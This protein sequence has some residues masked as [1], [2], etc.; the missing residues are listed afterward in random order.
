[1]DILAFHASGRR[2]HVTTQ[3]RFRGI[4][5]ILGPEGACGAMY[6]G[7]RTRARM[8]GGGVLGLSLICGGCARPGIFARCAQQY[9]LPPVRFGLADPCVRIR[10]SRLEG[11]LD[12][13]LCCGGCAG[14]IR[15]DVQ[16]LGSA[17]CGR[18]LLYERSRGQAEQIEQRTWICWWR[19]SYRAHKQANR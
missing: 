4:L 8:D 5:L 16:L 12:P 15:R 10:G 9:R 2:H 7:R 14:T 18:F 6:S 11:L 13:N 1:M 19:P 17:S 3:S